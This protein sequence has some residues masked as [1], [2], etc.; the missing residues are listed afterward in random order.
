MTLVRIV[1]PWSKPDLLR[2]TPGGAG[3]WGGVRFTLDPVERC[4][5]L[6]ILNHT[7]EPITV[8]I[9]PEHIW[10][11]IQE[12]PISAYRWLRKGFAH[13]SRVYTQDVQ[14]NQANISQSFG[15]LPWHL[16]RSY[17]QLKTVARPEKTRDL[18]WITSSLAQFEGHRRR[19]K[20][21]TRLQE[22]HVPFDLF[23]RG[24]QP[25]PDKWDGIA[26]YRYTLAVE[27]FSGPN[28]FTEK[29][30][31]CFLA[32]TMPIYFGATNIAEYFPAESFVWLEIDDP[33]APRRVAEIARS[34]LA[35]KNR[36]AIAEA[37][38]RVLDEQNLFPRLARL[39][40]EDRSASAA[41]QRVR[42]PHVPDLTQYYVETSPLERGW[43]SARRKLGLTN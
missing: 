2:Q 14:L 26:P 43:H 10:C 23:G 11:F 18:S 20:F 7:P 35:E 41:A 21:L 9:P 34:N 1:K 17:D 28:Y 42:L 8:E 24:F 39:I 32:W 3:V 12:P 27:N 15:S 30:A 33:D 25:L 4:D 16:D 37:R 6:V 29:I 13:Y 38:R 22:A 36:E 40:A 5:Y 19:L 31:D